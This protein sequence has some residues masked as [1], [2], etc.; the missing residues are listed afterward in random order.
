MTGSLPRGR[1]GRACRTAS[2]SGVGQ[3]EPAR[4]AGPGA[5]HRRNPALRARIGSLAI[6]EPETNGGANST[7]AAPRRSCACS[8]SNR[9]ASRSSTAAARCRAGRWNA[10]WPTMV[11]SS[12][13]SEWKGRSIR[14]I[15]SWSPTSSR[16]QEFGRRRRRRRPRARS[17][18]CSAARPARRRRHRRRDQRQEGR[19]QRHVVPGQCPTTEEEAMTEGYFR[20]RDLSFG[21]RRRGRLVGRLRRGRRRRLPE[22]RDRPDHRAGL[23]RR[24]QETGD[25]AGWPADGGGATAVATTEQGVP[26]RTLGR[27]DFFAYRMPICWTLFDERRSG[28]MSAFSKLSP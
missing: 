13:A 17:A 7:S 14:P 22:H 11:S 15:I 6:V 19:G 5:G 2:R 28:G 1:R 18:G 8:S 16:Q 27:A 9:A 26:A 10:R 3:T 4:A 20:K 24:L 25:P 21:G 23:S 12:A